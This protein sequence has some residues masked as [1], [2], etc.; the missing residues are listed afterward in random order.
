MYVTSPAIGLSPTVF[1][2]A[3]LRWRSH[4]LTLFAIELL[5]DEENEKVHIDLGFVKHFH[6]SN[7]L[8]LQ[9][10]QVLKQNTLYVSCRRFLPHKLETIITISPNVS[11][12]L[13]MPNIVISLTR[14]I[15]LQ[16][17]L[18]FLHIEA[19]KLGVD[20]KGTWCLCG[21]DLKQHVLEPA[22][23]YSNMLTVWT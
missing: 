15:Y 9:L 3:Q 10:Q 11:V 12:V 5:V 8:I 17:D 23:K 14:D 18:Y 6:H 22:E 20:I 16:N 4:P 21:T 1:L 13:L 7:S 2:V 19:H